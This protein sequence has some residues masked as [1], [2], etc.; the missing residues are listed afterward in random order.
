MTRLLGR[1]M[2]KS[3]KPPRYQGLI[4]A[5]NQKARMRH[6]IVS[7]LL[8]AGGSEYLTHTAGEYLTILPR[9]NETELTAGIRTHEAVGKLKAYRHQ[10]AARNGAYLTVR[11]LKDVEVKESDPR[12]AN[13][14]PAQ[15]TVRPRIKIN[16]YFAEP[17]HSKTK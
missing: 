17:V 7:R 11:A 15:N 5:R 14:P 16:A 12:E 6:S 1:F 9:D 8:G 3:A 10:L 13:S 4:A 2:R